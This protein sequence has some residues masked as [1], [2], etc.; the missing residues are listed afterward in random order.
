MRR[1]FVLEAKLKLKIF[2]FSFLI[3]LASVNS[4]KAQDASPKCPPVTRID[5]VKE[6]IHGTVVSD[7]YRWL[8]DQTGPE[9]RAWIDA[10]NSCTQSIL[11]KLP[12]QQAISKRLAE[13]VKVD[14]IALPSQR[15]GR[16]FYAKRL[17]AQD[18]Y[19][20]YM[21]RGPAGLEE[22]LVDPAGMTPDHTTSASFEGISDDGKI[23][24]Y[25]VR[26]GGE[27]EVSIHFLNTDT[28][29]DLPDVLPR[30]RYSAISFNHDKTGFYYSELKAEGPRVLYHAFG[31]N[32]D[33]AKDKIIF[34]DGFGQ[35]KIIDLD[36]S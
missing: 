4:V 16:Y 27:D 17:A 13:L 8:E 18:L 3:S 22:V 12:G 14:M 20:L 11:S 28:R 1:E 33:A 10:E 6:T 5:D 21:R 24:A 34:G 31:A 15:G 23:V 26:K 25:G 36:I 32:A 30:G 2:L 19:V 35:D 29:K 9:T 7:P